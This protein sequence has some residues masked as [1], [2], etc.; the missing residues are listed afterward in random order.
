MVKK[1]PVLGEKHKVAITI[2]QRLTS[3]ITYVIGILFLSRKDSLV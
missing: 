1:G 3:T 2:T